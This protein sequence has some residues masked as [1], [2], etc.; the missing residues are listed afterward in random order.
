MNSSNV[1]DVSWSGQRPKVVVLARDSARQS[2]AFAPLFDLI[3]AQCDVVVD[4]ASFS[5][6]L[7]ESEAHLAIVLGGDGSILHAARQM[8]ER[9]LPVLGVN[10]G[11]LGFLAATSP[12]E[13]DSVLGSV[14]AGNC[15]IQDHLM[16]KCTVQ[17]NGE[18]RAECL[19]LNEA[20]ILGGTPFSIL[21][22]DLYVD[23][24]WATS[25]SCDG[26]IISTPVGSTAHSLSAGGP[27]VQKTMDA[28]VISAISPHTLTVRPVVDSAQRVY[29]M[30]VRQSNQSTSITVDGQVI[31]DLSVDDRVRVT[32]AE[33]RF[34]LIEVEGHNDYQTLREKLDWGG[35]IRHKK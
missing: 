33:P 16:F 31:A 27:I 28:F 30:A 29:E 19:G 9:Q 24:K 14:V 17:R 4:D 22:I 20:A 1:S 10:L 15:H 6:P 23:S 5:S 12:G 8:G 34:R 11:K 13:L 32:R 2:S 25:Y 3:S 7:M 21:D 35:R 26:L 18:V